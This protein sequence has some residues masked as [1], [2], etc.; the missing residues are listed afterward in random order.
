[1]K[2]LNIAKRENLFFL[3]VFVAYLLY[4]V[5]NNWDEVKEGFWKGYKDAGIEVEK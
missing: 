3:L 1:M 4:G 2:K 5:I